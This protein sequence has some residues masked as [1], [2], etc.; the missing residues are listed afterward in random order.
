M[1]I[2]VALVDDHTLVR[3]GIKLLIENLKDFTVIMEASNGKDFLDQIEVAIERPQIILMDV[4][5]PVM[6]GLDTIKILHSRY[7]D[8]KIIALS[9]STDMKNIREMIQ[10]GSHAY[11]FKDALPEVMHQVILQVFEKG[12]YYDKFVIESLVKAEDTT[13]KKYRQQNT[14][15]LRH[16]QESITGRELEFIK[17]C[18]TELPY[19]EIADQMD[20]SI[21]TV[22]GYR[23]AVFEKLSVKSRIGLVLFAVTSGLIEL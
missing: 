5:M 19:K 14:V 21:R 1:S 17:L 15:Q 4:N 3:R 13:S 11:L 7:A 16:L 6:G 20:I 10:A 12:F 8:L 22:D 2:T 23:E 18:C 9:V